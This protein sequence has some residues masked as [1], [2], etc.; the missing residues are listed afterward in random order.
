MEGIKNTKEAAIPAKPAVFFY[1]ENLSLIQKNILISYFIIM[2][3]AYIKI[4]N[5]MEEDNNK[6][7]NESGL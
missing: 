3:K 5:I 7:D 1:W 6:K 4:I 2:C